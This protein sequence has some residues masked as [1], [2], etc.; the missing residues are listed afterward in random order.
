MQYFNIFYRNKTVFL[1][2]LKEGVKEEIC[3]VIGQWI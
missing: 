1:N 2:T 3:W